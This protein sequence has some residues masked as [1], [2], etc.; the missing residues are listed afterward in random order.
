M[1]SLITPKFK[2]ARNDGRVGL[3]NLV[4]QD[5]KLNQK[6]NGDLGPYRGQSQTLVHSVCVYLPV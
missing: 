2:D 4:S 1:R 6:V 5:L 3:S